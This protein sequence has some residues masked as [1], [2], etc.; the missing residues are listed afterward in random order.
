MPVGGA[1]RIALPDTFTGGLQLARRTAVVMAHGSIVG[2]ARSTTVCV[3]TASASVGG[4]HDGSDLTL[5]AVEVDAS[6]LVGSLGTSSRC[7]SR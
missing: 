3:V 7:A 1:G 6:A 2:N 5:S 4:G